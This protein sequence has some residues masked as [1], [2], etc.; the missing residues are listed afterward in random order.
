MLRTQSGRFDPSEKRFALLLGEL[1]HRI[2][3]LLIMIETIVRQAQSTSVEGYRTKL[4]ARMTGL[5]GFCQLTSLSGRTV[6]LADLIEQT[7]RPYCTSSAEVLAAGADLELEPSLALALHLVFDELA[8][9][10]KTYGALGSPSGRVR[11]EWKIRDFP[12]APRKLAIVWSEHG[13][14]KVK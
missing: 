9:N 14:A 8:A 6:N 1:D 7:M 5:Y 10:A 4:L 12:D 2:R 3:N 11:I 13:G